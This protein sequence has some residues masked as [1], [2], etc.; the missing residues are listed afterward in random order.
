MYGKKPI[1]VLHAP[2]QIFDDADHVDLGLDHAR[3]DEQHELGAVVLQVLAAERPP[4]IGM[5]DSKR[6]PSEVFRPRVADEPPI[7]IVGRFAQSRRS[8]P[9]A[10]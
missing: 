7:T 8:A 9:T 3:G 2:A 1:H 5:R 4:R 6:E 10:C